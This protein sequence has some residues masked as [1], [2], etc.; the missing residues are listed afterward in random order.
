MK[1]C[2]ICDAGLNTCIIDYGC[3]PLANN[4]LRKEQLSQ[5]E[6]VHPLNLYLCTACGQVQLGDV[7]PASQLFDSYL[8]LSSTQQFLPAHFKDLAEQIK[9]E[10]AEPSFI[11]E[12]GSNDGVFLK[13]LVGTDHKILGVEPAANVAAIARTIGVPSV[14]AYF[15]SHTAATIK[16][17]HGAADVIV[18]ANVIAH[19]SDIR[20][21]VKG[22]NMLLSPDGTAVFESPYLVDLLEGTLFD[23]V[24]HEHV[25]YLSLKPLM[26]LF[27]RSD[28]AII[29]AERTKMHGGAIRFSVMHEGVQV[30]SEGVREL[31]DLEASLKLGKEDG[32][33][34]FSTK[35]RRIKNDL[36]SLIRKIETEDGTIAG[37][38]ATAKGN[39]LCNYFDIGPEEIVCIGDMNPL[40]QNRYTPGKHIPV[41]SPEAMAEMKPDYVLILAWN[42]ADE[43]MEQLH[44]FKEEG[45]R[46]II[47][48]PKLRVV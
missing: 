10:L 40:K 32:W 37:Y 13:N 19:V 3:T 34:D 8:Y 2:K 22:V 27:A 45:G 47:P 39:T 1:T 17:E 6:P 43:I 30:P 20:D 35:V 41:V 48:L 12:V 7:V 44:D 24:Y 33:R 23:T 14:V 4:F 25:L 9:T 42:I 21:F 31:L 28:M 15:D 36:L 46:F 16:A 11:V 18:G 29:D 5:L 38:G 26:T